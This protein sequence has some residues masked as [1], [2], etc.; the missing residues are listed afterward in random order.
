[1]HEEVIA[2]GVAAQV[3]Q[4]FGSPDKHVGGQRLVFPAARRRRQARPGPARQRLEADHPAVAQRNDRLV[5]RHKVRPGLQVNRVKLRKI[6]AGQQH[7][8]RLGLTREH[9][10]EMDVLPV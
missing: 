7:A 10:D 5:D 8:A 1:M 4:R 3:R 2:P 9:A 6:L